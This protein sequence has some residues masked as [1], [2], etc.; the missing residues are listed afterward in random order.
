MSL[1]LIITII[2]YYYVFETGQLADE[3]GQLARSTGLH[4][5]VVWI[6]SASAPSRQLSWAVTT[7]A[8]S[9]LAVTISP[10]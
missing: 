2:T 3:T 4:G 10:A 8:R 9:L 6:D 7:A 5:P 1:L